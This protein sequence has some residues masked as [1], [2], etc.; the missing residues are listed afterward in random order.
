[1][2]NTAQW[3]ILPQIIL[4]GSGDLTILWGYVA[5]GLNIL[6]SLPITCY[7]PKPNQNMLC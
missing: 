1:M 4:R 7:M 5:S 2:A 6:D 3:G